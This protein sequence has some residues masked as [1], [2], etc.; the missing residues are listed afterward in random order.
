MSATSHRASF[1]EL[2]RSGGEDFALDRAALLIAAEEYHGLSIDAYLTKLDS[3]AERVASRL[4]GDAGP[5]ETLTRMRI[6]LVEEEGFSG[7]SDE[8]YDP[9]NSFLNDVLDRRVGIPIAL[10]TI[11]MEVGRRI[12][13]C[14]EGVGFPGHF[15]IKHCTGSEEIIIDPF[16]KARIMAEDDLQRQLDASFGGKMRHQPELLRAVTARELLFRMLSNLKSIYVRER[17]TPRALAA[18]ERMLVLAPEK[19]REQRDRGVL[20]AQ[21]DRSFEALTALAH[22]RELEPDAED[23]DSVESLM[24][25][26]KVKAGMCN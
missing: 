25:Q 13:F 17:D 11:Y 21:L 4:H 9:R 15:L 22:Y 26:L 23:A 10:S 19:G 12:G 24:E 5:H 2:V 16:H 18:V 7:N 20:L 14:L 6:V 1:N 8:Y 3:L